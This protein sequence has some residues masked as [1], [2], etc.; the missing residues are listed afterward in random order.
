MRTTKQYIEDVRRLAIAKLM[1][2]GREAQAA[3]MRTVRVHFDCASVNPMDM[4][5]LR[6]LG[7]VT[8]GE[9]KWDDK[10]HAT[11]HVYANA[12]LDPRALA[13]TTLH[14]M[15]HALAANTAGG[16]G[17]QWADACML[18]GL[19][20]LLDPNGQWQPRPRAI[21]TSDMEDAI[22]AL[23][24]PDDTYQV[25]RSVAMAHQTLIGMLPRHAS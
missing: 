25:E 23:E 24:T 16:H 9:T 10:G 14:E 15:G 8:A 5:H 1:R 13:V 3:F 20:I 17:K 22:A 19:D 7:R 4:L 6:M 2:D 18:L 12:D 21:M 11:V